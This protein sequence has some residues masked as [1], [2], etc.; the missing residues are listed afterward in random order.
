MVGLQ[1]RVIGGN[2]LSS[3]YALG[4][5]TAAASAWAL[6]YWRLYTLVIYT[7][8]FLFI[9]YCCFVEESVRWLI[10]KGKK[11]EAIRIIFK[12]AAMNKKELS[13]KILKMLADADRH[14]MA[15]RSTQTELPIR[16]LSLPEKPKKRSTFMQVMRSKTI[17][18]RMIVC[19]FWWVTVTMV[20]YGLSINSVS[21]AGN[22]HVNFML[23]CLV[24]IPG[25]IL[26]V[27]SLDRFGR[28]SSIMSAFFLCGLSLLIL[29]FVDNSK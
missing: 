20:Y 4:Q 21:L 18:F 3:T 24:E 12:A 19:S 8:S 22:Q 7:P 23:T 10:S 11:K 15:S 14:E 2:I 29:P 9:F 28:K 6:P 5:V 25:Y 13:P 26:S 27:I 1:K 16:G 17:L